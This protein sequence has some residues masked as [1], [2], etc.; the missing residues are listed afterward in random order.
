MAHIYTSNPFNASF[1]VS[2]SIRKISQ[3]PYGTE[4]MASFP[5]A[6]GNWGFVD[7]IKLTLKRKYTYKGQQ[8]SYFNAGC[9]APKGSKR[10]DFP[11]AY[12]TFSF[13]GREDMGASVNKACGVVG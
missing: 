2:F 12:V 11:L 4:L 13:A 5:E 8:L 3:G 9:P 10:T 1:V 6:L 7:R